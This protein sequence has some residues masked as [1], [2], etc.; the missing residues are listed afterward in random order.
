LFCD[1]FLLGAYYYYKTEKP[2]NYEDTL[3]AV[4]KYAKNKDIPYRCFL[5]VLNLCFL[6][7]HLKMA[8][9]FS[10]PNNLVVSVSLYLRNSAYTRAATI[11]C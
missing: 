2:L 6:I 5:I 10:H 11:E 9:H 3:L 8:E 4:D 1:C 7:S